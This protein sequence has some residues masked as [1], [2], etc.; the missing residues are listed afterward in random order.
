METSPNSLRDRIIWPPAGRYMVAVSGG[1]DSVVLLDIL[2]GAAGERDYGLAV[3]HFD[4]GMRPD[5]AAD[6]TFVAGLAGRYG[7]DC[8]TGSAEPGTLRGESAA[9]TARYGFLRGAAAA[10]GATVII[11]AHH[12]DDR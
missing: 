2:A 3:G 10:A 4:H 7:L 5:A 11:T 6:E 8:R 9:R 12:R 1:V